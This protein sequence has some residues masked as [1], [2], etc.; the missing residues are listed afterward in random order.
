MFIVKNKMEK[1]K[2]IYTYYL[3]NQVVNLYISAGS[4]NTPSVQIYFTIR[5]YCFT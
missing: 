5:L 1:E 4:T 3:V 2:N